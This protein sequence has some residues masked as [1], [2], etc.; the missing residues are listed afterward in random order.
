MLYLPMLNRHILPQ[1]YRIPHFYR[2]SCEASLANAI[3]RARRTVGALLV[4]ELSCI[5]WLEGWLICL[6]Q[7]GNGVH[8]ALESERPEY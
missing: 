5:P 6:V 2:P 1:S 7:C 3:D 4:S 8:G